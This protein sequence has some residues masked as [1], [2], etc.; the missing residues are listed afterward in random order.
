MSETANRPKLLI[1]TSLDEDLHVRASRANKSSNFRTSVLYYIIYS[2]MLAGPASSF[3]DIRFDISYGYK[4]CCQ[5][6]TTIYR[7][8]PKNRWINNSE[9]YIFGRTIR[10]KKLRLFSLTSD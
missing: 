7:N 6:N 2:A 5:N 9:L 4:K 3:A 10:Y 1:P 8:L